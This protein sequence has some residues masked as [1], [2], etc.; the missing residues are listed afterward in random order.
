M[1][2]HESTSNLKNMMMLMLE[3]TILSIHQDKKTEQEYQKDNVNEIGGNREN[4]SLKSE[5][6]R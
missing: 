5:G 2:D 3:N 1:R 4:L 6:G